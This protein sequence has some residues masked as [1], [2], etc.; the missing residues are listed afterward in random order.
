[1]PT[2]K[3]FPADILG[4]YGIEAQHSDDFVIPDTVSMNFWDAGPKAWS[5][6]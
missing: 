3:D 6:G 2:L 1:M 4:G 5:P